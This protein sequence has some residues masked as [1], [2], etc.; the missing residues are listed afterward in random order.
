MAE[1][2]LPKPIPVRNE[3]PGTNPNIC[4]L[5]VTN[6]SDADN[7]FKFT[8]KTNIF[9]NQGNSDFLMPISLQRN[10]VNLRY[11]KLWILLDP[12]ILVWNIKGL[13]HLVAKI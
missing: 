5:S 10:V 11:F 9:K 3:S 2:S 13:H 12:I 1:L 4:D 6:Q 8:W 7:S